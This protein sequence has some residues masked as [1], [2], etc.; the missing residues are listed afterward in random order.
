MEDPTVA[1]AA[2]LTQAVV[3][4]ATRILV[5]IEAPLGSWG[6]MTELGQSAVRPDYQIRELL[7]GLHYRELDLSGLDV[8]TDMVIRAGLQTDPAGFP[9]DRIPDVQRAIDTALDWVGAELVGFGA[10]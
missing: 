1:E 10:A 9:T 6:E 5:L 8:T 2:R 7:L 3:A 4:K